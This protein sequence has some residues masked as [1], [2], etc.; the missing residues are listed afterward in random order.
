M[1]LLINNRQIVQNL[2]FIECNRF[3]RL[4]VNITTNLNESYEFTHNQHYWNIYKK[5]VMDTLE[6]VV[7]KKNYS[8]GHPPINQRTL[9]RCY[10]YIV[11]TNID[12]TTS[13]DGMDEGY[14]INNLSFQNYSMY[15]N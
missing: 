5:Y 11:G 9:E 15:F 3:I 1:S 13:I 7:I 6:I 8:N 14:I 4:Y 12:F 2:F 10:V